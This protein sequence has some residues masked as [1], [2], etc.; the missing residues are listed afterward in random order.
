M[1]DVRKALEAAERAIYDTFTTHYP[2]A[3]AGDPPAYETVRDAG[4]GRVYPCL[5]AEAR[6]AV[7]AFLRAMPDWESVT[8]PATDPIDTPKYYRMAILIDDIEKETQA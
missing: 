6:A 4:V 7:L 5:Q 2:D 3:A 8:G 1:S